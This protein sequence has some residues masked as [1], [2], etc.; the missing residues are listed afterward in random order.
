MGTRHK[1]RDTSIKSH[2]Q[3]GHGK[4][5]I[6]PC[7]CVPPFSSTAL[8][9]LHHDQAARRAAEVGDEEQIVP[10]SQALLDALLERLNQ[11]L[12]RIGS[13]SVLLLH[14]SQLEPA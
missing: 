12:P 11:H 5:S 2:A 1:K 14:V 13:L 4:A 7:S 3:G 6:E 10:V 8:S 9:A